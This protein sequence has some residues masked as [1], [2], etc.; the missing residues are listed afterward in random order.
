LFAAIRW[1]TRVD[2]GRRYDDDPIAATPTPGCRAHPTL[3]RG[4]FYDLTVNPFV[5]AGRPPSNTRAES[6]HDRRGARLELVYDRA[7]GT[8]PG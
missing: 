5:T 7:V 3:G 8:V 1:A 4:L 6:Q 2:A